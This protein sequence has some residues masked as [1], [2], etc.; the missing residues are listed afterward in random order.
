MT[1]Y[2]AMMKWHEDFISTL[3]KGNYRWHTEIFKMVVDWFCDPEYADVLMPKLSKALDRVEILTSARTMSYMKVQDIFG[4][5]PEKSGFYVTIEGTRSAFSFF[6][7]NEG[8][9][10]RKPRNVET[11]HTYDFICSD[12]GFWRDLEEEY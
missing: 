11:R 5:T 7:N 6:M 8:E 9:L 12:E 1:K 10:V 3:A 2:D 4:G